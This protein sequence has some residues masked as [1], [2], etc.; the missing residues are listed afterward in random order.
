MRVKCAYCGKKFQAVEAW[1]YRTSWKG[2]QKYF[3]RWDH[4]RAFERWREKAPR[5]G[6]KAVQCME[7]GEVYPSAA[8]AAEAIGAGYTDLT[9]AA[10]TG[11]VCRGRHW[12]YAEGGA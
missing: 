9:R 1:A 3:C 11:C 4:L 12:R 6:A 8:A 5:K 7:T 2:A 10:R